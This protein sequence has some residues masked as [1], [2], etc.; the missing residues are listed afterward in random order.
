[1]AWTGLEER[2]GVWELGLEHELV[3]GIDPVQFTLRLLLPPGSLLLENAG[4]WLREFDEDAFT[5]RWEHEDPRVDALWRESAEA[6]QK[7][8]GFEDLRALADRAGARRGTA[9]QARPRS[10]VPPPAQ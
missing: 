8:A 9:L 7:G 3:D 10:D 6:A 2:R 1:T 4:L 5:W